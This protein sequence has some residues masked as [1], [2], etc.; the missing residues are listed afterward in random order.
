MY[1]AYKLNKQGDNI[2]PW[3]TEFVSECNYFGKSVYD[4]FGEAWW[5]GD[6]FYLAGMR[7][8]LTAKAVCRLGVAGWAGAFQLGQPEGK[9]GRRSACA[10]AQR[11]ERSRAGGFTPGT[12]CLDTAQQLCYQSNQVS[13]RSVFL[14]DFPPTTTADAPPPA[15]SFTV[16]TPVGSAAP[17][18]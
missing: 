9:N 2:Q 1:S 17:S 14:R 8:S 11:C 6:W 3:R 7:G 5:K 10:K 13:Q 18:I 15:Q 4:T 16:G 12:R